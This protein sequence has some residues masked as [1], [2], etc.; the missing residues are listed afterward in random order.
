MNNSTSLL[1]TNP[2]EI[3]IRGATIAGL[4]A[5]EDAGAIGYFGTGLKYAIAQVLANGGQ[6]NPEC[7]AERLGS[8]LSKGVPA[9]SFLECHDYC[10]ATLS[11]CFSFLV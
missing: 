6:F 3:D 8:H 2:G 11:C 10:I 1:F 7:F 4:S 5:K 9:L